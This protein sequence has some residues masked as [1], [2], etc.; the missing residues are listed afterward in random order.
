MNR[1]RLSH[2]LRRPRLGTVRITPLTPLALVSRVSL[3]ALCAGVLLACGGT[4]PAPTPTSSAATLE[5]R[6]GPSLYAHYCALCHG[7]DRQ[8][9]A[10][11][12]ANSLVH[13]GFLSIYG[14]DFLRAAIADGRPGTAMG[15]YSMAQDGPLSRQD[16]DVLVRWLRSAQ[17]APPREL[18]PVPASTD[19]ALG[20]SVY[21]RECASCHGDAGQGVTAL[22]LNNPMFLATASDAQL[23]QSVF[24]GRP[25]T[26]MPAFG[27]RLSDAERGALVAL[28]R[29]W[30]RP[31]EPAVPGRFPRYQDL[32][33]V[34]NPDGPSPDFELRE[35]RFVPGAQLNEALSE[36]ARLVLLDARPRSDWHRMHLPG[37]IP[38][39]YY[40]AAALA[41]SL[42]RDGTWIIAYCGCP[43][44]ASGRVRDTLAELGF[45]N[46][47]V[48][49]EGVYGWRDAGYPVDEAP[50]DASDTAPEQAPSRE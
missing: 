24:D 43:H 28:M 42:P 49:D 38:S 16:I 21:A 20:A 2:A 29:S 48:L 33:V 13:P 45:P 47:A 32:P 31:L 15:A 25:G 36:G 14:D 41:E 44:A 26:P 5:V 11:D 39:P 34:V 3:M 40:E 46:V 50:E 7:D 37:A 18:R 8:G 27:E 6:D 9:Y 22:S 4:T 19:L 23:H 35:G 17:T 30:E 1:T 12:H 10:A